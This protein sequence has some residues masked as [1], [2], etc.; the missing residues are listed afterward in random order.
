M[1]RRKR[2]AEGIGTTRL[3][4]TGR[5]S[6]VIVAS[7]LPRVQ[8][9]ALSPGQWDRASEEPPFRKTGGAIHGTVV[10]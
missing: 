3:T 7:T 8:R 2:L 5:S 10:E 1:D 9:A 4:F 6:T